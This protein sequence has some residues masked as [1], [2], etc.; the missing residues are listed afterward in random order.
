[1]QEVRTFE[2]FADEEEAV[3]SKLETFDVLPS[4]TLTYRFREDMLVRLGYG[5]TLNRPD[6]REMSP[7]CVSAYIGGGDVCG[8]P[9]T[10]DVDGEEVP[11]RLNR[12]VI[13][14]VDARWEWYFASDENVSFGAFYKEF[15]DPIESIM[16]AGSQK[17]SELRNAEG[18][19]DLGLELEFRKNF[20]FV[21]QFM[22]DWYVGGNGA[23]IY[24]RIQLPESNKSILTSKSRPLQGQSPYVINAQIGYE[25][26]DIG[27][28]ATLLYN[29]FGPR[30]SDVGV[31]QQPDIY[32][33][34]F[35]KLDL[36]IKQKLKKGFQ[37]TFKAKNLIDLPVRFSQ[38][39]AETKFFKKGRELSLSLAWSY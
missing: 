20:G 28:N 2:P 37:L 10:I 5:K 13:H 21:N 16:R 31:N 23:W 3:K 6:F 36:V 27:L 39:D 38:G 15:I 7:G 25:N 1:V 30:I 8:A 29:V 12:T 22:E 11:Y 35:H 33:E 34:P 9:E 4:L 17:S 32:E 18:A 24:S 26:V 19:R 14:N